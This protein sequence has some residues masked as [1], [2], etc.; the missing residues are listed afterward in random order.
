[1]MLFVCV[2]ELLPAAYGEKAAKTHHIT[3]AFF[4][5]CAVMASS[6]ILEKA[7]ANE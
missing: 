1:M 3:M 7:V 5:G 2:A 4:V 6:L